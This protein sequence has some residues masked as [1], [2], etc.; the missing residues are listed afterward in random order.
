MKIEAIESDQHFIQF[1]NSRSLRQSSIKEYK[2]RIKM[3]CNI[4]WENTNR[5]NWVG[6]R[7]SGRKSLDQ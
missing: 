7:R 3:Y 1:L 2:L 5:A 6:K 4:Y